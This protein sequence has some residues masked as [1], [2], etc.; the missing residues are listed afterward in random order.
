MDTI[1]DYT[2]LK[3]LGQGA[4]GA[5]YLAEHRFIKRQFALKVLPE[6]IGNDPAFIRRFEEHVSHIA[7]LDH[8]NI[9]KIHN[10]SCHNG[11]YFIVSDPVVDSLAE[12]MNFSINPLAR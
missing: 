1:G 4:F 5:I 7:S 9:A 8:P 10:V 12:T 2:I 6:E 3:Q 11:L